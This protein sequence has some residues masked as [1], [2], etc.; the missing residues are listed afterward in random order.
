MPP[1]LL[2]RLCSWVRPLDFLRA[3]RMTSSRFPY[4]WYMEQNFDR[5]VVVPDETGSIN[6]AIN[7]SSRTF[8][9][10]HLVLIRPG[11]YSQVVRV[12]QNC[13][14]LG[15]GRPGTVIV[16]APGWESALVSAGLGG[17]LVP[18]MFGWRGLTTGDDTCVE[19]MTFRCRNDQMRGRCVYIVMGRM[20][21]VDCHVDGGVVVSGSCTAPR[22][23]G[24]RI[25]GS[26][27]NG[28]HLT[29]HCRAKLRGNVVVGHGRHG[30][31]IDRHAVPE[32]IKNT[33]HGN[34]VCGIQVFQASQPDRSIIEDNS[35]EA[36]G[37][38]EILFSPHV[39]QVE[40]SDEDLCLP[41]V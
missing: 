26:R 38:A 17:S 30:I 11:T 36:N 40:D 12:T 35:F 4:Q 41:A 5:I 14:L 27:G 39:S 16:E 37:E 10:R 32:V 7:M 9:G 24:C 25:R 3:W 1:E 13:H 23:R 6:A 8:G 20:Q 29:D 18:A 33:I 28:V 22:L 19:N 2:E 15:L 34:G 21:L 31:C